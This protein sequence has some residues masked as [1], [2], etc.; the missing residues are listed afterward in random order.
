VLVWNWEEN[1]NTHNYRY[2]FISEKNDLLID[3]PID[4]RVWLQYFPIFS[5]VNSQIHIQDDI[6]VPGESITFDSAPILAAGHSQF[7]HWFSDHLSNFFVAPNCDVDCNEFLVSKHTEYQNQTLE[8]LNF[9]KSNPTIHSID[10][11]GSL[12]KTFAI[13]KLYL[14]ANYGIRDRFDL[15]RQVIKQ[16]FILPTITNKMCYMPRGE[17][18]GQK[19]IANENDILDV[20]R[21]YNI[22]IADGTHFTF[23]DC[24]T[25]YSKY[26]TFISG[27]SAANTNFALFSSKGSKFLYGLASSY[28]IPSDTVVVGSACYMLPKLNDTEIMLLDME[29]PTQ[30]KYDDPV[31]FS[32]PLLE[33]R[34]QKILDA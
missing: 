34:I 3:D 27:P 31:Y 24:A 8:A 9:F 6:L 23:K 14:L 33:N 32:I 18:R 26:S 17:L 20:C 15:L 4:S 28:Q 16:S 12:Y 2:F 11:R 29:S 19:R 7:A 30:I 1:P 25:R 22:D 21:K 10:M 5:E 13:N